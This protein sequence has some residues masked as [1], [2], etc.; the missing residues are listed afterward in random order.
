VGRGADKVRELAA[1]TPAASGE[2][3]RE[4][5][6][7]ASAGNLDQALA[8]LPPGTRETAANAAGERFLGGSTMCS[9]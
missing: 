3:P 4:L 6:E 9:R 7:A 2:R 1:G 8:T 5:V